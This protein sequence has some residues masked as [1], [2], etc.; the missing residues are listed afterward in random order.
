MAQPRVTTVDALVSAT[1]AATAGVLS[2]TACVGVTA[3]G[4]GGD[5]SSVPANESCSG[6][7]FLVI[8]FFCVCGCCFCRAM[9]IL[10]MHHSYLPVG[11]TCRLLVVRGLHLP[12]R[13]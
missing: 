11:F 8:T 9:V 7:A 6:A 1:A 10:S 12:P 4:T 5:S 2:R 13:T 3:S